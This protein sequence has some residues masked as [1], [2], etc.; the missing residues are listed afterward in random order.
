MVLSTFWVLVLFL[1]LSILL[2]LSK[3]KSKIEVKI[4]EIST[5]N[6]NALLD[7]YGEKSNW[8]EIYNSKSRRLA[9]MCRTPY[10][11]RGLKLQKLLALRH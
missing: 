11:V 3:C 5:N 7:A 10:G 9:I 1:L 2:C 8:I 4:N 6:N